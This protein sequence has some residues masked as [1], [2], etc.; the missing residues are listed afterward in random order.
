[1]LTAAAGHIHKGW[2]LRDEKGRVEP[3]AA[4]GEARVPLDVITHVRRPPGAHFLVTLVA[5][6]VVGDPRCD[7]R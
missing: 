2:E 7:R 5:G 1:M 3:E 4:P 6:L